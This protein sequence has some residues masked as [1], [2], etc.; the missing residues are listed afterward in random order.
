MKFNFPQDRMRV[1]EL[2]QEHF[3]ISDPNPYID[4]SLSLLCKRFVLDIFKF[5]EFLHDKFG[6]YDHGE[7][8]I[9][10]KE[11]ILKKYGVDAERFI[12]SLIDLV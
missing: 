11:L 6:N 2:F 12:S 4:K 7:D 9:S 1:E 10:M 3:A 8:S 5:D